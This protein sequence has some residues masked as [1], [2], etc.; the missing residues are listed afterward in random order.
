MKTIKLMKLA[1]IFAVIL[2]AGFLFQSCDKPKNLTE[3]ELEGYWVLKTINGKEA[4]TLFTGAQPTLQFNFADSTIS[5]TG[6][7]NR[8]SGA[9]TYKDGVFAAPNLAVTQMLCVEDNDEGQFLLEL[10]NANNTLSINNGL[11]T[12]SHDGKVVL[13]F[14]KGQESSTD[15]QNVALDKSKLEGEW[16]LKNIDGVEA[17]SK[18]AGEGAEVP[19]I[20]FSLTDNKVSG[21]SGC[22]RY[23]ATFTIDNDQL[24]VGAIMS[25]KMACPNM[26]GEA[27]FTQAISDTSSISI[28]NDNILQLAK[29]GT[30]ILEFEKLSADTASIEK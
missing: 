19:T 28:P 11:L 15:T 1:R 27:Q 14:E 5:G 23:N 3:S 17:S 13:E 29:N 9:Y 22:N 21:Y 4:K 24:I 6:G 20:S 12:I 7:C 26:E 18:F 25:T 16:K 2:V 10:S 30:V 8:Y